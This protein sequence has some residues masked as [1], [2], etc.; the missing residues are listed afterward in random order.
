MRPK[1]RVPLESRCCG[2][3]EWV[4]PAN[5]LPLFW[6]VPFSVKGNEWR[7]G[8]CSCLGRGD[9]ARSPV[10]GVKP[11][12]PLASLVE[13]LAAKGGQRGRRINRRPLSVNAGREFVSGDL[14]NASKDTI[15][16]NLLRWRQP[17]DC[18]E[19]CLLFSF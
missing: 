16:C 12:N 7:D 6:P 14:V 2:Y 19:I 17:F 13:E 11:D 3:S 9:T 4:S 18:Q 10:V 15:C 8:F 5:S 1:G